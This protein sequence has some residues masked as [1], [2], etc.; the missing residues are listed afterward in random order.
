MIIPSVMI[1]PP[2]TIGP[3]VTIGPSIMTSPNAFIGPDVPS[4]AEDS[5]NPDT[6]PSTTD[7]S[8]VLSSP[9]STYSA[10]PSIDYD[11]LGT[12]AGPLLQQF[13][14][15]S[16]HMLVN[17]VH[18]RCQP[19]TSHAELACATK[20]SLGLKMGQ[21]QLASRLLHALDIADID[22]PAAFLEGSGGADAQPNF[23]NWR[24]L[25]AQALVTGQA[26]LQGGKLVAEFRLWD[27]NTQQQ[28]TGFP[29][30]RWRRSS[31][32]TKRC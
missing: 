29:A 19:S 2:V 17:R 26:S 31:P 20:I 3:F 10:S 6:S 25:K 7:S 23:D 5:T 12:Y 27:V 15:S 1:G 9:Q 24:P 13:P 32:T 22:D 21:R 14:S 30:R 18:A 8:H 28:L 16:V 11:H 4:G